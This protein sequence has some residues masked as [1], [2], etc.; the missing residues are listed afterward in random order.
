MESI[1]GNAYLAYQAD[2]ATS[3]VDEPYEAYMGCCHSPACT[4]KLADFGMDRQY[5]WRTLHCDD[6]RAWDETAPKGYCKNCRYCVTKNDIQQCTWA[7]F[8]HKVKKYDYCSHYNDQSQQN[9]I[10]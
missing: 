1:D 9:H 4:Q 10:K 3:K 5:P 2:I 6:C 7:V 8:A